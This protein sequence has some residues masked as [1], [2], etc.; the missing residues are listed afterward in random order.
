MDLGPFAFAIF[1]GKESSGHRH[2]HACL[3]FVIYGPESK[4]SHQREFLAVH[5]KIENLSLYYNVCSVAQHVS[6]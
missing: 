3:L 2:L 4:S 5:F 6:L 1:P